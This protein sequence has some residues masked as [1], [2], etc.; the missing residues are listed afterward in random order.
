MQPVPTHVY[1][2]RNISDRP[3]PIDRWCRNLH[4]GVLDFLEFRIDHVVIGG[5]LGVLWFGMRRIAARRRF[6]T[7]GS[8]CGLRLSIHLSRASVPARGSVNAVSLGFD[9]GLVV[10]P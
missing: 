4:V 5:C 1:R 6:W 2:D 7:S 8:F 10:S 3:G 9:L